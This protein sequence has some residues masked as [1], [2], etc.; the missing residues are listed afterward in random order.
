VRPYAALF[1]VMAIHTLGEDTLLPEL[2]EK[3]LNQILQDFE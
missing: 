3:I 1:V 2:N